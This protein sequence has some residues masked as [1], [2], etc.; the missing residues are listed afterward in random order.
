MGV[1]HFFGV[2]TPWNGGSSGHPN[3]R[4][5]SFTRICFDPQP[6]EHGISSSN[7][8]MLSA[9]FRAKMAWEILV[10]PEKGTIIRGSQS[11]STNRHD[12]NWLSHRVL[13]CSTTWIGELIDI[14]EILRG[15]CETLTAKAAPLRFHPWD[16]RLFSG[17]TTGLGE[18][19]P[20]S[21]FM[22]WWEA[23]HFLKGATCATPVQH[24]C[25]LNRQAKYSLRN[26]SNRTDVVII[27][28]T[29]LSNQYV[30]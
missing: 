9:E 29:Q 25:D 15:T 17:Y 7:S 22:T 11:T 24:L 30:Y 23:C 10:Q 28:Q 6:H 3:K 5:S 8:V 27:K 1:G 13:L 20:Y 12:S 2:G 14:W 21:T 4:I 26:R 16:R 19:T 18:S